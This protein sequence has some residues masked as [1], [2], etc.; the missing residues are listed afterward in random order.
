MTASR[1][2]HS[3]SSNGCTPSAVKWRAKLRPRCSDWTSRSLVA[4][5]WGPLFTRGGGVQR[6]DYDRRIL[7]RLF[8]PVKRIDGYCPT[9]WGRRARRPQH[10]VVGPYTP[11]VQALA[12]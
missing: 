3:T 1:I 12:R 10:L 6:G 11:V 9:S 4:T 8:P 5:R 7:V 2:S